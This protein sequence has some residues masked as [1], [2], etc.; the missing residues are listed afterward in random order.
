MAQLVSKIIVLCLFIILT[1]SACLAGEQEATIV[2]QAATIA[3][4]P[5]QPI[6]ISPITLLRNPSAL[7]DMY[8][9][10]AGKYKQLPIQ[11]CVEE[12][13]ASPIGWR[14]VIDDL[15]IPASGFDQEL[16]ELAAKGLALVVEGQWKE[17]EGPVGCGRR[18]PVQQLWY[19][20]VTE[21][22][23]PNP[24][25]AVEDEDGE[26]SEVP[27][28]VAD[29][30]PAP[31]IVTVVKQPPATTGPE[32]STATF[33][34]SS[35]VT[36]TPTSE[37]EGSPTTP[38]TA[39]PEVSSTAPISISETA[40]Q[41]AATLTA[42][43]PTVTQTGNGTLTPVIT[44]T[45]GATI[46]PESGGAG[47]GRPTQ[48]PTLTP[49]VTQPA[50]A[51][52]EP[53]GSPTATET[54]ENTLFYEELVTAI[55]EAGAVRRWNFTGSEDE[56]TTI[57]AAPESGIDIVLELVSPGGTILVS[58]DEGG[59][60]EP[61]TID[62]ETLS[63]NGTYGIRVKSLSS[64]T[65]EFALA[66]SDSESEAF[67]VF[68]AVLDYGA[69]GNGELPP[70]TD[71]LY[72][73]R[74]A[75]QESVTIEVESTSANDLVLYLYDPNGDELAFVDDD[76]STS[77]GSTEELLNYFLP[78][79]GIYVFRIGEWDFNVATYQFSLQQGQ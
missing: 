33:P 31:P 50:G 23:S 77:I 58:Q 11:V 9:E 65:G 57:S 5:L 27:G 35:L 47:T 48:M 24:L 70:G 78:I 67:L 34:A 12:G 52:G 30:N 54:S 42:G 22:I 13:H 43:T 17:W 66:L 62:Q 32:I 76:S 25:T 61:E 68:V 39:F 20:S 36:T 56:V 49:L 14:L 71:H 2:S 7:E 18:A 53:T 44:P 29:I 59:V 79:P 10:L 3:G 26:V 63:A 1:V 75:S 51:T 60:G 19:L 21:I 28:S 74:A 38:V 40:T 46:T 8:I 15:E 69:A 72:A 64:I 73:F 4:K 16:R 41:A 55:V 37:I 6:S 45:P